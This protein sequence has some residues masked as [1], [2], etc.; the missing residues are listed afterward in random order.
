MPIVY[1]TEKE[2]IKT[3]KTGRE[4][5]AAIFVV[6]PLIILNMIIIILLSYQSWNIETLYVDVAGE[7][8]VYSTQLGYMTA[9]FYS[10]FLIHLLVLF[11]NVFDFFV[12]SFYEPK[13]RWDR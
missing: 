10:F 1:L 2:M 7:I 11:K 8:Q 12:N 4:Y 9:V 5:D 3:D 13:R 6:V